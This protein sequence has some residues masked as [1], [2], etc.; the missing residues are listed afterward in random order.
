LKSLYCSWYSRKISST[1][2][3]GTR[4]GLGFPKRRS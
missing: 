4:F 3:S 1:V 2:A